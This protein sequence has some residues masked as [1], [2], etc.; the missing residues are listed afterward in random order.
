MKKLRMVSSLA[1]LVLAAFAPFTRAAISEIDQNSPTSQFQ[2][3]DTLALSNLLTGRIAMGDTSETV[4]PGGTLTGI[5]DGTL[6]LDNGNSGTVFYGNTLFGSKLNPTNPTTHGMPSITITLD[7]AV[8]PFGYDLNSLSSYVGWRDTTQAFSNQNYTLSVAS[9]TSP[10]AFTD[11]YT[12]SYNPFSAETND[13]PSS[14]YVQLTN[15]GLSNIAAIK[16][17]FFAGVASNA[18]LQEGQTI[19]EAQLFGTPSA[20]PEP[21]TSTLLFGGIA[22][23]LVGAKLRRKASQV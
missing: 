14:T 20:V 21:A 6:G 18:T 12:V 22:V 17:T 11:I 16:L 3:I 7:L 2:F 4:G 9:Y 15:L 19:Q 8:A 5:N 10:T 23:V 1:I 13:V